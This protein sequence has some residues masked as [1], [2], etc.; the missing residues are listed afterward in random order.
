MRLLDLIT[1]VL[2]VINIVIAAWSKD[3]SE[4][5]AWTVVVLWILMYIMKCQ[6]TET[7]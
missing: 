3:V 1:L 7:E 2:A 4:A 6:E 5:I